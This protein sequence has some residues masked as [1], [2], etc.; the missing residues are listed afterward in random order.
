[1]AVFSKSVQKSDREKQGVSFRACVAI[2]GV[3]LMGGS[4]GLALR[5]RGLADEVIG[6]DPKADVLTA[7]LDSGAIDIGDDRLMAGVRLPEIIFF[8]SPGVPHPALDGTG[9]R[10]TFAPIALVT[11]L[12]SVKSSI[13]AAGTRLFGSRFV[14]RA[15]DGG[16]PNVA[17][18]QAAR[19]TLFDGAAWAIVPPGTATHSKPTPRPV[20]WRN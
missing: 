6:I 5:Q 4:L 2:V 3:G 19:A 14:R 1:L 7:A 20:G 13:V 15:S 18:V 9:P 16:F 11:D 10:P 8:R 12:G 17:V